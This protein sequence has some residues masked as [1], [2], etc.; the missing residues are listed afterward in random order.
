MISNIQRIHHLCS[1]AVDRRRLYNVF[2]RRLRARGYTPHHLMNLFERGFQLART[3]PAP[4]LK[5]KAARP[6]PEADRGSI[7]LH[8][9]YHPKNPPSA[10]IQRLFRE[11]FAHAPNRTGIDRLI[12]AYSRSRNLGEILSYRQ[13][14]VSNGPPVSSFAGL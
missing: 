2:Y 3:N 4:T 9:P 13:I 1:D 8:L 12:I 7:M 10:T 5:N 11:T 14:T 6:A